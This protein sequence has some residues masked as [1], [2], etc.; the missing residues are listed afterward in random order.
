[1]KKS[2][3]LFAAIGALL[4]GCRPVSN[5]EIRMN[6]VG[7]SPLQEKTATIDVCCAEAQPHV[8]FVLAANG[9]T[10]WSGTGSATMLNPVSGKP[11][12]VIDFSSVTEP[13]EY[14]LHVQ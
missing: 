4:I 14:T 6:Q 7:F 9:D 10:V 13:G 12:Q 11:R 5:P 8:A 3:L 1:M 2:L